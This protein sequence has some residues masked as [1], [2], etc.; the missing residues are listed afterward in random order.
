MC[1]SAMRRRREL[2]LQHFHGI[3]ADHAQ[4]AQR[5]RFRAEQQPSDAGTMHFDADAID[6]GMRGGEFE[7]RFAGTEADFEHARRSAAEQ[8]LQVERSSAKIRRHISATARRARA[9]GRPSRGRRATRN[10]ARCAYRAIGGTLSRTSG[11]LLVRRAGV[12]T[13]AAPPK[14][15]ARSRA[16]TGTAGGA[17]TRRS[18]RCTRA[19]ASGCTAW[20]P[21]V[22]RCQRRGRQRPSRTRRRSSSR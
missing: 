14:A 1:T 11:C 13:A 2:V 18:T 17:P 15:V 20:S 5:R 8:R 22:E 6:L 19:T 9:A 10:C 21:R 12:R 16:C 7:Q 4:I 3:V